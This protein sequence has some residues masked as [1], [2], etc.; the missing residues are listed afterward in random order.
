MEEDFDQ[1]KDENIKLLCFQDIKL[2][3]K[4]HT[5]KDI[6]DSLANLILRKKS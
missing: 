3:N 1:T 4:G 6:D 2:Q 5:D